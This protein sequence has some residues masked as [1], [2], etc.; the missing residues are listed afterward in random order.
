MTRIRLELTG[1]Y[2]RISNEI[3]LANVFTWTGIIGVV[4]FS[5]IFFRA[6]YL[7]VNRS[8]SIY[9]KM[10]GIYVA[11]R[12]LYSWIEDVNDFSLNYFML[13]VMI[14]LCFSE[15]FRNMTNKDITIWVR[16]IFDVRYVR[17][18]QYLYKKNKYAKTEYSSLA[19]VPQPEK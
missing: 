11:F 8:K 19:N 3:G 4:L 14:G 6:S 18:Q 13:M 10:L 17:L 2:E 9:A 7:A 5:L 15:S 1:R 16:G 12:W